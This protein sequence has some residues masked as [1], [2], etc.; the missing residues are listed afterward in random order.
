MHAAVLKNY[1][2]E[3]KFLR[4]SHRLD[5]LFLFVHFVYL[6]SFRKLNNTTLVQDQSISMMMSS[7]HQLMEDSLTINGYANLLF[8]SYE[9]G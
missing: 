1:D 2:R 4:D 8:I 6:C 3:F 5:I 7:Q 9:I